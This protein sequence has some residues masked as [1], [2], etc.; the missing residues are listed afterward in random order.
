MGFEISKPQ[1]DPTPIAISYLKPNLVDSL[2]AEIIE[3]KEYDVDEIKKRIPS[4]ISDKH[5]KAIEMVL[6]SPKFHEHSPHKLFT[7]IFMD[8]YCNG[9]LEVKVMSNGF[10][11]TNN[12]LTIN[13]D[14]F[15]NYC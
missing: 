4:T 9:I 8:K 10:H 5:R 11:S 15:D 13:L 12:L 6:D 1:T 14:V 2:N 7:F 3:I